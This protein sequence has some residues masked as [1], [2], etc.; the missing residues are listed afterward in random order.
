MSSKKETLK[1]LLFVQLIQFEVACSR[2]FLL[3]YTSDYIN[4]FFELSIH[5][6]WN[7]WLLTFIIKANAIR[8]RL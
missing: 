3:V 1:G 4:D 8:K 7:I 2:I 6:E 5:I